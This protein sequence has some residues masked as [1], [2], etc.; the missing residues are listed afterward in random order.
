MWGK[1]NIQWPIMAKTSIFVNKIN[2]TSEVCPPGH[3]KVP[4]GHVW[5]NPLGHIVIQAHSNLRKIKSSFTWRGIGNPPAMS[6][7][8]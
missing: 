5:F 1:K 6:V 3:V 8:H 4:Q 7:N 2:K